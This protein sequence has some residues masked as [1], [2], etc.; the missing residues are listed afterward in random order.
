MYKGTHVRCTFVLGRP[1]S[2][3]SAPRTASDLAGQQAAGL[4]TQA[5]PL[6][7]LRLKD[8]QT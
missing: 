8:A 7:V 2:S 4:E 6:L 3:Q 5:E 1:A